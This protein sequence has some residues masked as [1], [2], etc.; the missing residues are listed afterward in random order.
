[1]TSTAISEQPIARSEPPPLPQPA[2]IAP[3]IAVVQQDPELSEF[4]ELN[5]QPIGSKIAVQTSADGL[6]LI[7][8]PLGWQANAGWMVGSIVTA[9][10]ATGF[11]IFLVG[12][13][14]SVGAF[15]VLFLSTMLAWAAAIGLFLVGANLANRCVVFDLTAE[16]LVVWQ[17]ELFR[18]RP[19]RWSREQ[20]ADVFVMHHVSQGDSPSYWE[21]Q[22]HLRPGEGL[23]FCLLDHRDESELRWLA[24]LLRRTLR[25]P[26]NS[27]DS[28][29]PG[30][31]VRSPWLS[32]RWHKQ[33][34]G[35]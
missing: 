19:R 16:T 34:L 15:V 29:P 1:V 4:E 8:P 2:P 14:H 35:K 28:P 30:F 23:P 33:R 13:G 25:C 17:S 27:P 26:G 31:V 12:G 22:I 20:L 21:L 6:T 7:V 10:F 32:A 18:T 24:T 3:R 11:S 5:E 9:L